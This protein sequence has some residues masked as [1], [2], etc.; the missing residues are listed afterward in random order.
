[1]ALRVVVLGTIA[2]KQLEAFLLGE[3]PTSS[4]RERSEADEA[5]LRKIVGVDAHAK[6]FGTGCREE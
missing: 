5:R 1:M 6:D 4:E 3:D 2:P